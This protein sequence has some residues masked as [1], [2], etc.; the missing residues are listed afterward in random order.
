MQ[1]REEVTPTPAQLRFGN[2]AGAMDDF[3][4]KGLTVAW[5]RADPVII[6]NGSL[7]RS[8]SEFSPSMLLRL[9]L[10][11]RHLVYKEK[12]GAVRG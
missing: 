12:R 7:T 8:Q 11:G 9:T 1:S 6:A 10:L 4:S 2:D 3:N 5:I